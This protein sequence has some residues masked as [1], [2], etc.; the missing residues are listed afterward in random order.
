[1]FFW[2]DTIGLTSVELEDFE[3]P[4]MAEARL[5]LKDKFVPVLYLRDTLPDFVINVRL[6]LPLPLDWLI[7]LVRFG[8]ID[9]AP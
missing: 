1:M 2:L 3:C 6:S 5:D 8:R 4:L 7:C 9:L